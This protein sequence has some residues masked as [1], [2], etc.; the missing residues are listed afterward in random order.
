MDYSILLGFHFESALNLS[1][2]C[3]TNFFFLICKAEYVLPEKEWS[4]MPDPSVLGKESMVENE[5]AS[6]ESPDEEAGKFL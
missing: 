4:D 6:S 3:R 1:L 2:C 5:A